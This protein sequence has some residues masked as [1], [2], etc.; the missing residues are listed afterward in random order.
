[1]FI[2]LFTEQNAIYNAINFNFV[3]NDGRLT[4][5]LANI[6]AHCLAFLLDH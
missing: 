2:L 4:L 1:M 5:R 3:A 6:Y